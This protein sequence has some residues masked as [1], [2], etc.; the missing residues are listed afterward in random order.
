MSVLAA[1]DQSVLLHDH[2]ASWNVS[3]PLFLTPEAKTSRFFNALPN[4]VVK[5]F[6]S[7]NVT[8]NMHHNGV[9]PETYHEHPNLRAMFKLLST[10]YDLWGKPFG[11]TIEAHNYPFYATQ[12][13]PERNQFDWSPKEGLNKTPEA[14]LAMQSVR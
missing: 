13:H 3:M 11:S 6:M 12:W 5:T 8:S 4:E 1:R 14:L 9:L 2:Y 7:A 10:N